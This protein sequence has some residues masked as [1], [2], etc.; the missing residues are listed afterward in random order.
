ML[1][2]YNFNPGR[3]NLD[4]EGSEDQKNFA[5]WRNNATRND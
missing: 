3:D 1:K 4:F 5:A 2:Y